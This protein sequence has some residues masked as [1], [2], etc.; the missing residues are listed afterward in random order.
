MIQTISSEQN[1]DTQIDRTTARQMHRH[2]DSN[3]PLLTSLWGIKNTLSEKNVRG[4]DEFGVFLKEDIERGSG[5]G[6]RVGGFGTTV[7]LK[8]TS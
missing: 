1:P 5:V 4:I 6:W 2:C 8:E 3:T 7:L